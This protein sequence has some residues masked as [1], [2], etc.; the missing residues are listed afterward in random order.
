[1]ANITYTPINALLS[2]RKRVLIKTNWHFVHDPYD[3]SYYK[4]LK[5]LTS[6]YNNIASNFTPNGLGKRRDFILYSKPSIIHEQNT[7][8]S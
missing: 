5:C 1:M 8:K 2:Q 6:H 3:Y 4:V 7:N